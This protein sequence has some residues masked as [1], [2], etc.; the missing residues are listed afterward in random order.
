MTDQ[1]IDHHESRALGIVTLV[2]KASDGAL[3]F[4]QAQ[5]GDSSAL[6]Q[7]QR[8]L[9]EMLV[10]HEADALRSWEVLVQ[11][12][13]D[14]LREEPARPTHPRCLE[15]DC[16]VRILHVTGS[17]EGKTVTA[18]ALLDGSDGDHARRLELLRSVALRVLEERGVTLGNHGRLYDDLG[19]ETETRA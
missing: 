12:T 4:K 14:D 2:G 18:A 15:H 7:A 5:L 8:D 3:L 1:R 10:L 11:R 13:I 16:P 6:A 17:A 19:F 9:E